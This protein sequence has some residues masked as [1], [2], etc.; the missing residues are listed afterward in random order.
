MNHPGGFETTFGAVIIVGLKLR[1][2]NGQTIGGSHGAFHCADIAVRAGVA[3]VPDIIVASFVQM[4]G[5]ATEQVLIKCGLHSDLGFSDADRTE[6]IR[7]IG[8]VA[9]L[10]VEQGVLTIVACIS[11]FSADRASVSALFSEGEFIEVFVDTPFDICETRDCK[12][13]Y[14]KAR[15]N[16]VKNFTGVDSIYQPPENPSIHLSNGALT[17]AESVSKV[18]QY[19]L[20][21]GYIS[22]LSLRYAES[23]K[24]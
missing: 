10:F 17:V 21:N 9:K 22:D 14:K 3:P 20:F 8:E 23:L 15:A 7:R 6:N 18:L 2:K 4:V 24:D 19:L 11:P 13:L 5:E 1:H 12:G 16:A